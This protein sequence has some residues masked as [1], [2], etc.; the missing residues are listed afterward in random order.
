MPMT[1]RKAR[2]Q[3]L[4]QQQQQVVVLRLHLQGLQ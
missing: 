4:Q 2:Q 3:S 1:Q